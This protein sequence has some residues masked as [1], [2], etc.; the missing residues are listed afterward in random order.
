MSKNKEFLDRMYDLTQERKKMQNKF[1]A[2]AIT[3]E[4]FEYFLEEWKVRCEVYR[5][6][7]ETHEKVVGKEETIVVESDAINPDHYKKRAFEVIQVMKDTQT[8]ERHVGYLEGCTI[9]Y[10]MRWDKKDAPLQDLKK[11]M[12][13][14]NKL[15][16][17]IEEEK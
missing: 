1:I 17:T 5:K 16:E 8:R 15:I 9:K 4:Q 11:A 14:L 10:L 6:G 7:L 12:W 3:E 13:Y 2:N